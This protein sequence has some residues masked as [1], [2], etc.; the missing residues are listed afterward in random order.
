MT[1]AHLSMLALSLLGFTALALATERHAR[2]LL[3]RLPTPRWRLL[4]RVAGWLLLAAALA[5]GIRA[6]GAD[7]G[8]T[9]WL[10]WLSVAALAL[11]FALPKWPWQPAAAPAPARRT[12]DPAADGSAPLPADDAFRHRTAW[13]L[14]A[15]TVAAF[16][17]G[18]LREE[19]HPLQ[20]GDA[21]RGRIGPWTFALAEADRQPPEVV[22]MDVPLKAYR[23][24]F[25]EACDLDIRHA[26]LKVKRPRSLR[27]AGMAFNGARWE[28]RVEIQLP[29]NLTAD[30]ELW[31]TVVG[32]DGSVH[33][34]SWPMSQ[35]SPATVA[36]FEQQRKSDETR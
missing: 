30:S 16:A 28:R 8:L 34:A 22:D 33:Q 1:L 20:R 11:V 18:L 23:L 5:S 10:G 25:C 21:Q 31:L 32:K 13:A 24:R 27:A 29:A 36:W 35:V 3:R 17:V 7:V 4:A 9:L 12:R 19:P 26:Y 14:L 2:H 6:L 15:A